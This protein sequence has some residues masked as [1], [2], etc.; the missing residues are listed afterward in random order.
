MAR[1]TGH[2][3]APTTLQAV[4]DRIDAG[5]NDTQIYRQTGVTPNCTR[6]KRLNLS[7]WG[8]PYAPATVKVGRP[9]TLRD[10]H[11][12]R[13]REYLDGRPQ[14]YLEEMKDWLLDEFNIPVSIG[15]VY[16]ELQKMK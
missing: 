1:P 8:Q 10:I 5:V 16:Q 13:L 3:L 14:A 11:R 15:L 6:R 2:K 12:H 7:Q 9:T 4:L